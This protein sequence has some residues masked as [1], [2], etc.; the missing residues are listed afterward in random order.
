MKETNV[1]FAVTK[2]GTIINKK[3]PFLHATPD[4][5]CECDCCR[6]GCGE[7]K[8]PFCIEGLDFDSYV[9]MKS[10]CLEKN[11]SMERPWILLSSPATN[12][13]YWKRLHGFHCVCHRG[14]ATSICSRKTLPNIEHWETQIPKLETFRRICV[15][16]EMLGHWYTRKM[17]M[18]SQLT[19]EESLQSW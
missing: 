5:L 15:L 3:Y 19:P 10:S 8:C 11:G 9:Q 14:N 7:V 2:C 12:S 6:Q 1:N 16:P 13:H 4:F 18:K 17:N